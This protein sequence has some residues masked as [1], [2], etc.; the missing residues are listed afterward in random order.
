MIEH[1][2]EVGFEL[3]MAD[4]IDELGTDEIVKHIRQ[5]IGNSPVYLRWVLSNAPLIAI[6]IFI[7]PALALTSTPSVC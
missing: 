3:I 4:D 2:E 1:D 7:A 6:L 5:R